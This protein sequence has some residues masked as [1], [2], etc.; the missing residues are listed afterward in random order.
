MVRH[1]VLWK[2]KDCPQ[3]EKRQNARQIKDKLEALRGKIEGLLDLTVFIHLTPESDADVL[4][5]S[6]F[7]SFDSLKGYQNN[8]LH[9]EAAGF[10]RSVVAGRHCADFEQL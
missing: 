3:K 10:V 8:P 1:L 2:L 6:S 4:L 7:D 9:L 5:D